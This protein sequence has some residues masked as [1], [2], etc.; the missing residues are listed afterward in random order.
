MTEKESEERMTLFQTVGSVLAAMFG[1]QSGK[2]RERDFSRGR[3]SHFIIIGAIVTALFVLTV[4][5]VVKLVTG[6]AGA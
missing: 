4:W 1:V 5:G 2:N 3:P 6:L